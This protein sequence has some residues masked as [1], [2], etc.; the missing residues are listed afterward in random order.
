[1]VTLASGGDSAFVVPDRA[2]CL[3]ERR[4]VPGESADVALAEVRALISPDLGATAELEAGRDPWRLDPDGPAA[5]LS[6]ALAAALGTHV[7]FDAPYWMEAP[8]WQAVC[9][10]LI[11]GPTG[12]GMHAID[13]WVD[14]AQVRAFARAL[15]EV[16]PV[17]AAQPSAQRRAD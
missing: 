6:D 16:L 17:W 12:G 2:E 13:E 5:E 7:G 10:T 14:L 3:V 9:P 8:L 1:M 4:T 15:T 11:C